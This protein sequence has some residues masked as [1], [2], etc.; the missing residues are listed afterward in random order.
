MAVF[1]DDVG[2]WEWVDRSPDLRARL[3][4]EDAF[5]TLHGLDLD[6]QAIMRFTSDAQAMFRAWMMEMQ[7]EARSGNLS[8]ILESHIL[9]TPRT[10]ASLALIFELLEGG[11]AA[12]GEVATR[13]AL[14]W[15]DYLRSHANR[16][17]AAGDTM[18]ETGAKLIVERRHLLPT[19]FT[20]RDIQRKAW[21]GLTDRDLV[22]AAIEMLIMTHHCRL[23]PTQIGPAGGRPS[24]IFQWNPM[25]KGET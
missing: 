17:Y 16:L 5:K 2:S 22:Q 4:Y 6:G 14:G 19:H 7:A 3:A 9:K 15:A 24:D 25:L 8:T 13:R 10:I 11:R 21:A 23:L 12:V 20:A 1:P 18:V